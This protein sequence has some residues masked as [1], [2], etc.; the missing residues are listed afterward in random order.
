MVLHLS[1]N[2]YSIFH[3]ASYV[4]YFMFSGLAPPP[5]PQQGCAE[6]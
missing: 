4:I 5:T 3:I 6:D 1:E 2:V